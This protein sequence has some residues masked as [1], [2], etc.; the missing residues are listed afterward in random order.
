MDKLNYLALTK[1]EKLACSQATNVGDR[2]SSTRLV[3]TIN[4][5]Y[6]HVYNS[7]DYNEK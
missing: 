4:G 1:E 7:F 5:S 2:R 3:L 6:H